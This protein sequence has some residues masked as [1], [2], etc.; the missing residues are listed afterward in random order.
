MQP[1]PAVL[2]LLL[3]AAGAAQSVPQ[4]ARRAPFWKQVLTTA[5]F[6]EGTTSGDFDRDGFVDLASGPYWWPGP[7]F[8]VRHEVRPAQPFS[9]NGYSDCFLEFTYDFDGDGWDDLLN[10][11]FPGAAATWYRNPRRTGVHWQRYLVWPQVGIESPA[12]QDLDRDGKPELVCSTQGFLIR[13]TPDPVDPT[14][15]WVPH[16]LCPIAGFGVFTHGFGVGDVNGD[17][18]VDLLL[19]AG[20]L[21]QPPSLVG[22]PAWVPHPFRFGNGQGG[23]QMF[24]YDVDGDGDQDV[25]TSINAHAYGLSWFEHVVV[26]N[27]ITFVEHVVQQPYPDPLD[28]HQ[29][30][31][32]HALSLVD[33]DGDG[34]RDIVTGKRFWAH[35]GNDPGEGDPALLYWF[36]L[37]RQ[38]GVRFVPN[39]VDNA[40]GVGLQVLALDLDG[41]GRTDLAV[42]NKKGTAVLWQNP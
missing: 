12:F 25:I 32:L 18:R 28:P 6:A 42:G 37:E 15:L 1:S 16:L 27:Q 19:Q 38:G 39:L 34:L 40:S 13:L 11:D 30:S 24:A 14:A 9:I 10:V 22:D 35:N 41:D 7:R 36:R 20:W 21:E 2:L 4:P 3:A 26:G 33:V 17:G 23:A 5:F 29:L 8:A 31:Q